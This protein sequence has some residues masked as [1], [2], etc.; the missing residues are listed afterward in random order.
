[1]ICRELLGALS[2][3]AAGLVGTIGRVARADH[4]VPHAVP[5]A[6]NSICAS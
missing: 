4:D 1:M 2:V 5:N 6:T 3:T